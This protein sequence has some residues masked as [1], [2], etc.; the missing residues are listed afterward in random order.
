MGPGDPIE[1]MVRSAEKRVLALEQAEILHSEIDRLP[2]PFRL[3]VV[4]CYL[5]GLTLDEAARRLRCPPARCA[6][7]WPGRAT[8]SA[9][10]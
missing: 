1:P 4:L 3:P 5:E 2:G 7:D 8:S 10:V 6:A 9:A